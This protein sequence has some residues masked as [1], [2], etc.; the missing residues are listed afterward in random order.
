MSY[1]QP[2]NHMYCRHSIFSPPVKT[3]PNHPGGT[4][5]F[6]EALFRNADKWTSVGRCAY[7]SLAQGGIS[8]MC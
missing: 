6:S 5:D 8:H 3:E 4:R 2:I 7:Q 1:I